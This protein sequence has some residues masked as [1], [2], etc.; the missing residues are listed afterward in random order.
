MRAVEHETSDCTIT[1]AHTSAERLQN[2]HGCSE[3][4]QST[5]HDL[6]TTMRVRRL[7]RNPAC[8]ECTDTSG[9]SKHYQLSVTTGV[10]QKKDAYFI[11]PVN[12]LLCL[13]IGIQ[14]TYVWLIEKTYTCSQT[15]GLCSSVTQNGPAHALAI[16]V[17]PGCHFLYTR[18]D[19]LS[20]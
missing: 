12:L 3:P 1:S 14:S 9:W 2:S 5:E 10:R 15:P 4:N 11:W 18:L 8:N 16:S 7:A 20:D 13:P 6:L 19:K 17:I